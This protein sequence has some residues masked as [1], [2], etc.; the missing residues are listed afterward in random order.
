MHTKEYEKEF[1]PPVTLMVYYKDQSRSVLELDGRF[2]PNDLPLKENFL[3]PFYIEEDTT[4]RKVVIN[5][6]LDV[7]EMVRVVPYGRD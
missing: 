2:S 3:R 7:V 6:N 4:G 5:I 1:G